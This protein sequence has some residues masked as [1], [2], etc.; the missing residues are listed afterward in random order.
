MAKPVET[1]DGWYVLHD[2]RSVDWTAWKGATADERE[3]A[4]AELQDKFKEWTSIEKDRNGSFGFYTIIGQKADLLFMHLRP[5][6]EELTELEFAFNKLMI[7]EFL[8]PAYS[9][10]SVVELSTYL[11][12]PEDME[13]NPEIQAR[14]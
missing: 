2:F 12:K 10:V 14:L 1:V 11:S 4:L 9:Y 6:M 8:E 7:A 3:E 13:N 5:T